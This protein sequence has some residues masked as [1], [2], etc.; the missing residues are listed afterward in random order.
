MISEL[1]E[2]KASRKAEPR[3]HANGR[4]VPRAYGRQYG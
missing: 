2:R 1:W 3:V 4:G